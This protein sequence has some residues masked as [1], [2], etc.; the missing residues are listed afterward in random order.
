MVGRYLIQHGPK[1]ENVIRIFD[2]Y[3]E[4]SKFYKS[5][6]KKY[7]DKENRVM[8]Y[9]LFMIGPVTDEIIESYKKRLNMGAPL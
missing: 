7:I 4:A 8:G 1:G 2:D 3:G 6:Q 9:S 5:I